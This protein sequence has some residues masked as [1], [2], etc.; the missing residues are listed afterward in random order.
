[1]ESRKSVLRL[2]NTYIEAHY[3]QSPEA[4]RVQ[5]DFCLRKFHRWLDQE[6]LPFSNFDRPRFMQFDQTLIERGLKASSRRNIRRHLQRYFVWLYK[7]Q[8]LKTDPHLIF[9]RMKI[10]QPLKVVLPKTAN[11]FLSL[12]KT[13]YKPATAD[14]Y[15]G[16]L[17]SFYLFMNQH[18]LTLKRLRRSHLETFM[19]ERK[20]KKFSESTRAKDLINTRMYLRWLHENGAFECNPDHLIRNRD[21]PKTPEQLPRYLPPDIDS[22]LQRRLA[23]SNDI[24]HL[25][26]FLMRH[27][28]I[29]VSELR[30]LKFDCIWKNTGNQD[31]LKVEIGKLN[32][33][34]LIPLDKKYV[35]VIHK[36]QEKSKRYCQNPERL[37]Y[38]SSG[39]KPTADDFFDAFNEITD[40][41]KTE[42]PIVSHQLRHT[43]ATQMLNAGMS[44]AALKEILGHKSFR[45]T[46]IY[47]KV[48]LQTVVDEYFKASKVYHQK[49]VLPNIALEKKDGPDQNLSNVI[50]EIRRKM[51]TK[52]AKERHA[53]NLIA[54][55]LKRVQDDLRELKTV[56]C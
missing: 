31:F 24:Y 2:A 47:A 18:H 39:K 27:T 41:I 6:R 34:R 5:I 12:M 8:I 15:K 29:R 13:Q 7:K 19:V 48:H 33:E 22:E 54:R 53:L 10:R 16:S 4:T 11:R 14:S 9:P 25:S 43:Y 26:F 52:T 40:G 42:K 55:R 21:L 49:F 17:R 56:G 51:E 20:N 38:Q 3:R 44:M 30:A 36:I 37:I 35:A 32:A 1:M 23:N 28:G 45:M 50:L 46:A